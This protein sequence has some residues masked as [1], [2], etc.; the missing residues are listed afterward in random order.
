MPSFLSFSYTVL[1]SAAPPEYDHDIFFD[2][3]N[4]HV[5]TND[6]K[7]GDG[8]YCEATATAGSVLSF[9]NLRLSDIFV[10]NAV[11]L[12]TAVIRIAG[13]TKTLEGG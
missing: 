6:I 10:K 7:Y 8:R 11:A 9:R 12:N 13:T 3:V 2:D 5:E 4:I 1:D